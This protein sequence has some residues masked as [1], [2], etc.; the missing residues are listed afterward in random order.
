MLLSKCIRM[1]TVASLWVWAGG[2]TVWAA[3]APQFVPLGFLGPTSQSIAFGVSG[4][5]TTAVGESVGSQG[6]EAFRWTEADGLVGL[7]FF[8]HQPD[9]SSQ[10]HATN[11]DGTIIVGVAG[12][13]DALLEEG[14]PFGWTEATGMLLI[15]N[16]GGSDTGGIAQSITP[17]GNII[18][19]WVG[20]PTGY[21]AFRWT[22]ATSTQGLGLLPNEK[23]SRALGVSAD[24]SVIVGNG[25]VDTLDFPHPFRWTA[26]TG[27]VILPALNPETIGSANAITPDGTVI[28]GQSAGRAVRWEGDQVENL[29]ELPGGSQASTYWAQ[30]VTEDGSIVTGVGDY[31]AS[32]GTGEAF[33]WD[34]Q[35]G[36]RSLRLLLLSQ[37]G[38]TEVT[39]WVLFAATGMSADGSV[40]VGYGFDPQGFQE[41]WLVRLPSSK[42]DMNCDGTVDFGDI[43]PFVQ[44]LADFSTWQ[45]TYSGCSPMNGDINSDGLYPDFGDINPFVALLT[46]G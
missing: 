41:G 23:I 10:A 9:T 38:L 45:T 37:Y 30:A 32:Q 21:Q 29:G 8:P 18:V 3:N 14:A 1:R 2:T 35:H 31:N 26:D 46:G 16:L 6:I 7:G 11:V 34:A 42:G 20:S 40:I 27:K 44:Y 15:P 12:R 25:S 22:Q 17:D 39:D 19:G 33:I 5:G 4:D 28:V 13:P 43:N 36:M 24:G